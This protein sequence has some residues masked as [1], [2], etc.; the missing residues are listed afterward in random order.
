FTLGLGGLVFG[1][2]V[3]GYRVVIGRK[4]NDDIAPP[5]LAFHLARAAAARQDHRAI[6][7]ESERRAFGV[8]LVLVRVRHGDVRNPVSLGHAAS[9]F[10]SSWPERRLVR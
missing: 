2:V 8:E 10:C 9:S 3:A 1:R 5:A 7:L 4:L 6:F